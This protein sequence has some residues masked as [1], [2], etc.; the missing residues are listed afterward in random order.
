MGNYIPYS[1]A[2]Y[3]LCNTSNLGIYGTVNW[4][5]LAWGNWTSEMWA[6]RGHGRSA[7]SV[8][9]MVPTMEKATLDTQ[10]FQYRQPS[11]LERQRLRAQLGE[12]LFNAL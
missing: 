9:Q 3:E 12:V 2:H 4:K 1:T 7:A 10:R 5:E 8:G 11:L 6:L